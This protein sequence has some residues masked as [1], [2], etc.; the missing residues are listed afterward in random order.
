MQEWLL[1]SPG[2]PPGPC[3]EDLPLPPGPP[4]EPQLPVGPP[5]GPAL[6][7]QGENPEQCPNPEA[8]EDI[9]HPNTATDTLDPNIVAADESDA[10]TE[11][12]KKK[13]QDSSGISS[14]SIISSTSSNR[15]RCA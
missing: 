7:E 11:S 6:E 15:H 9:H 10:A 12:Q 1:N 13:E 2:P 8:A 5:P 3:P 4:T 14:S